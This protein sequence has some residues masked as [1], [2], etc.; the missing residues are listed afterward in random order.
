MSSQTTDTASEPPKWR[1][2]WGAAL[3]VVLLAVFELAVAR[4]DWFWGWV[5]HSQIGVIDALEKQ[6]LPE[7]E[8]LV[9]FTGSSRVRDAIAP[10]TLE[11]SLRLPKHTV[12][13]LGLTMGTPFDAEILYRR[14]R[15]KLSQAKL[16][17]FGVEP[18]QLDVY[19]RPTERILRYGTL[20]DRLKLMSRDEAAYRVAGYVWRTLDIGPAMRRFLKSPFKDMPELPP[21]AKDGRVQWRTERDNKRAGKRRVTVEARRFFRH[22]TY[23]PNRQR[24][25]R[26]LIE[27][28]EADGMT[29]VVFQVPARD[30]FWAYAHSKWPQKIKAYSKHVREAAAGHQVYMFWDGSDHSLLSRNFYDYGHLKPGPARRFTR[31]I[32]TLIKKNFPEVLEEIRKTAK[33]REANEGPQEEP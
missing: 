14:N 9:L 28:Y 19:N 20:R 4:Q 7:S 23:S 30:S 12:L 13:N 10:R 26:E 3:A 22:W 17:F 16:V 33:A 18:F 11:T 32:G 24:Q 2:P 5:P 1:V 31:K 6:V 15:A 29:V 25:L 8:P 21:L 27:L